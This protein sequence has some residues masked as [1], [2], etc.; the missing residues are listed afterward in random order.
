MRWFQ[1]YDSGKGART[2]EEQQSLSSMFE[3]NSS[4]IPCY[5]KSKQIF[6]E[7]INNTAD[8]TEKNILVKHRT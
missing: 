7:K 2:V 8:D 1:N 4:H 3:V 5:T 6:E